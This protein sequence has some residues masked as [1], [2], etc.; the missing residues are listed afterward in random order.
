MMIV[1]TTAGPDTGTSRYEITSTQ[2]HCYGSG[3]PGTQ[4]RGT[5]CA[6]NAGLHPRVRL[7]RLD[8]CDA[9]PKHKYTKYEVRSPRT[10]VCQAI[11]EGGATGAQSG[12]LIL[13]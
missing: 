8:T 1:Q 11:W 2:L 10:R 9:M 6:S 3:E 13:F 5:T 7:E 4:K 12:S